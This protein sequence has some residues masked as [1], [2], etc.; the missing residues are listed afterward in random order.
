MSKKIVIMGGGPG[1]YEAAL[2]ASK[3]GADITLVEGHGA[4]GSAIRK[5]VVP[6]K[7]FIA[8]ANIKT[9]LRR[10]DDM[11]LNHALGDAKLSLM[12]LNERVKQL[13]GK[14]SDDIRDQLEHLLRRVPEQPLF[15]MGRHQTAERA[16]CP[17]G[18]SPSLASRAARSAAKSRSAW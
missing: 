16:P 14:Q 8:G 18:C 15:G 2:L 12:A 4:G 5:D 17:A 9:D 13:A 6:S 1:G 10:A 11:G 7:S 3:H